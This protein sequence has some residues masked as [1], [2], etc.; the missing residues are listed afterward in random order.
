MKT[1]FLKLGSLKFFGISLLLFTYYNFLISC[2]NKLSK[3]ISVQQTDQYEDSVAAANDSLY[4]FTG[5]T[6]ISIAGSTISGDVFYNASQHIDFLFFVYPKVA[7]HYSITSVS[8]NSGAI[9]SVSLTSNP[10]Y[11]TI[12]ISPATHTFSAR[13]E[14]ISIADLNKFF[15]DLLTVDGVDLKNNGANYWVNIKPDTTIQ[16]DF[17][18]YYFDI[19]IN[20]S[21]K[22]SPNTESITKGKVHPCPPCY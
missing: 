15:S 9:A 14:K 13:P 11:Q 10:S 4:S 17:I 5:E 3:Q 22:A 7:S 6:Q 2:S 19:I 21:P 18:G 1:K 12:P 8:I 16:H 20:A